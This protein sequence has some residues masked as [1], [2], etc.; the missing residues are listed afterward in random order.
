MAAILFYPP[1]WVAVGEAAAAAAPYVAAG[2]GIA[3]VGTVA[4]DQM[5]KAEEKAKDKEKTGTATDT[6]TT[7]KCPC[8]RVVLIS[9]TAHPES[10]QHIQDAQAAGHPGT[11]TIERAGASARRR[12]ST[13]GFP[14]IPG[15]QP[16]EYPPAMFLE[17]G[18]GASVRNISAADNMGAGASMGNQLRS[19]PDGCKATIVV[20]P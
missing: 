11:L 13:G 10:A 12:A 5:S 8:H 3:V 6:C 4:V 20:G 18:A 14:R 19:A 15:M 7:G 1:F 16:D 17:G 9:K 2:L